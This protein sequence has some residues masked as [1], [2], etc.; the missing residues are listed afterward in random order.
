MSSLALEQENKDLIQKLARIQEE[1][2]I[3]EEK[4]RHLESSN[5]TMANDLIQYYSNDKRAST[6]SESTLNNNERTTTNMFVSRLDLPT[7]YGTPPSRRRQTSSIDRQSQ[8][9]SLNLRT[10]LES[11]SGTTKT[12]SNHDDTI[13]NLQ[14][15]LEE[16]ITKNMHLQKDLEVMS[17]QLQKQTSN[18][19]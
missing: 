5:S 14:R 8:G 18:H 1:R 3:L 19:S 10:M 7:R 13:R 11:I 16:T 9:P 4:V 17:I 12:Q 2:A 6:S 15:L